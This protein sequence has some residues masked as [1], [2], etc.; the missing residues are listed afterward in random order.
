MARAGSTPGGRPRMAAKDGGVAAGRGGGQRT[1]THN[2]EKQG[3]GHSGGRRGRGGGGRGGAPHRWPGERFVTKAC[4]ARASRFTP[5]VTQRSQGLAHPLKSRRIPASF[6]GDGGIEDPQRAPFVKQSHPSPQPRSH[7]AATPHT[8]PVCAPFLV[9]YTPRVVRDLRGT[10][11]R[12]SY[13]TGLIKMGLERN[14]CYDTAMIC[15]RALASCALTKREK[16]EA[17]RQTRT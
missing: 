17:D 5:T 13:T 16:D 1:H 14:A 10:C 6:V 7:P 9:Q 2:H 3:H 4:P 8:P 15:Q 12:V 11:C